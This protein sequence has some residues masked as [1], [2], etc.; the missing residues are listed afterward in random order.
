MFPL[1]RFKDVKET[2]RHDGVTLYAGI[3]EEVPKTI[4]CFEPQNAAILAA[5]LAEFP[6]RVGS[7]IDQTSDS[8]VIIFVFCDTASA[9]VL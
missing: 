5:F 9:R 4:L 7:V 2:Y 6:V 3:E 8:C 1:S